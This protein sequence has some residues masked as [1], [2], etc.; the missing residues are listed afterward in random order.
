MANKWLR[1]LTLLLLLPLGGYWVWS[2]FEN[3]TQMPGA[4]ALAALAAGALWYRGIQAQRRWRTALDA[5]AERMLA[6]HLSRQ[7]L[8]AAAPGPLPARH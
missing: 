8:K 2:G 1:T 4:L 3:R 7:R 6:Q 5:Y